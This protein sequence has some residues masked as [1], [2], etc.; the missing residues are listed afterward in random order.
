MVV[1]NQKVNLNL[2]IYYWDG[3]KSKINGGLSYYSGN[4]MLVFGGLV[5]ILY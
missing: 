4:F 5:V 1:L 2:G 3:K